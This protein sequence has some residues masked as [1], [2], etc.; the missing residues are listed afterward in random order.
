MLLSWTSVTCIWDGCQFLQIKTKRNQWSPSSRD[1]TKLLFVSSSGIDRI[2]SYYYY[3]L[4]TNVFEDAERTFETGAWILI[5]CLFSIWLFSFTKGIF[6]IERLVSLSYQLIHSFINKYLLHPLCLSVLQAHETQQS[7]KQTKI[8]ALGV[9][10]YIRL[11][12]L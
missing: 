7:T 1:K 9:F 4:L 6:P 3:W 8:P 12:T 10:L 11:K 5:N 2:I